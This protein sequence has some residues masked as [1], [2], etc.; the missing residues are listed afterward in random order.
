MKKVIAL[1]E[2]FREFLVFNN[3]RWYLEYSEDST[4]YPITRKDA[5]DILVGRGIDVEDIDLVNHLRDSS[6][7]AK[8]EDQFHL[9]GLSWDE[10]EKWSVD[11][12]KLDQNPLPIIRKTV[13]DICKVIFAYE[14]AGAS[15]VG[16]DPTLVC[17]LSNDGAHEDWSVQLQE[18]KG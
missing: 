13:G 6:L 12:Y 11:C 3:K 2:E 14:S 15:F 10:M 18:Y 7:R 17:W 16:T 9:K 1:D 4:P 8:I 5:N